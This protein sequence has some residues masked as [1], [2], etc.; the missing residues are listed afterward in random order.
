MLFSTFRQVDEAAA[1]AAAQVRLDALNQGT[2]ALSLTL[3][4]GVSTVSAETPLTLTGFRNGVNSHRIATRISHK[5]S[6]SDNF[7][8]VEAESPTR[9]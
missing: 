8:R 1:R 7:T 3:K 2:G 5:I 9:G 4:P 6:G